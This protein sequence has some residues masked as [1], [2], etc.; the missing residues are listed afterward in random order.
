MRSRWDVL[1]GAWSCGVAAGVGSEHALLAR[2]QNS[3]APH[4]YT[5]LSSSLT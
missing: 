1:Q 3:G 5:G 2:L 4:G